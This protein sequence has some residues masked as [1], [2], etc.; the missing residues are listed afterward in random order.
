MGERRLDHDGMP[1]ETLPARALEVLARACSVRP[2]G[3]GRPLRGQAPPLEAVEGLATGVA[4][5]AAA[6]CAAPDETADV[7]ACLRRAVELTGD[8]GE[9]AWRFSCSASAAGQEQAA[10]A[11]DVVTCVALTL[12]ILAEVGLRVVPPAD[13]HDRPPR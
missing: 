4:T 3:G 8:V 1:W 13:A 10:E 12:R 5:L 6:V 11:A 7:T 9:A 2:S